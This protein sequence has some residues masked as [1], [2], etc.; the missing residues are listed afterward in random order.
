MLYSVDSQLAECPGASERSEQ[1]REHSTIGVS[2]ATNFSLTSSAN[3]GEARS[4][5]ERGGS[6]IR[7]LFWATK[8]KNRDPPRG[9][10]AK[11]AAPG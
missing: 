7:I 4:E 5:A 1:P 8:L 3:T 2:Q 9:E 6:F 11:R 10:R